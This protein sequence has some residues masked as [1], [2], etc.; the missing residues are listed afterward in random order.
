MRGA[1]EL[2][3]PDE[4][5]QL[6]GLGKHILSRRNSKCKGLAGISLACWSCGRKVSVARAW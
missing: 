2:E 3:V 1:M 4:H 6:T 5:G